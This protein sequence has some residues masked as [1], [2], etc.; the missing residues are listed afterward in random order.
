MPCGLHGFPTGAEQR[1]EKIQVAAVHL[2]VFIGV[3]PTVATD[4]AR[5]PRPP[6]CLQPVQ[7][8][9][10]AGGAFWGENITGQ[11]K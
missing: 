11:K 10:A 2:A 8:G 3:N 9:A 5:V 1:A 4:M 7:A 6:F